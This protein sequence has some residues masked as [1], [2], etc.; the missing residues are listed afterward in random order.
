MKLNI[1]RILI[2]L[3]PIDQAYYKVSKN[4]DFPNGVTLAIPE[5]K[6]TSVPDSV[7]AI[8]LGPVRTKT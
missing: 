5:V 2:S 1:T 7:L 6:R 4:I 3:E 8:R